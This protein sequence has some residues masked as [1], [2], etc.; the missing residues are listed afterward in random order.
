MNIFKPA[1]VLSSSPRGHV[2]LRE[3]RFDRDLAVGRV[4]C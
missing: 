1:F 2:V 3:F 4:V